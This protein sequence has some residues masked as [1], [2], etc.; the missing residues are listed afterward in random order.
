MASCICLPDG[1]RIRE[2][3]REKGVTGFGDTN[4]RE[5][6]GWHMVPLKYHVLIRKLAQSEP[7][8]MNAN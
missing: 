1:E 7:I 3:P 5:E 2:A 4:W 6:L 8:Q